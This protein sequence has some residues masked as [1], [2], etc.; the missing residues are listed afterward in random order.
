MR[1]I[2]LRLLNPPFV[3]VAKG[4]W[5]E[6]TRAY[7]FSITYK[8]PPSIGEQFSAGV[9]ALRLRVE[10]LCGMLFARVTEPAMRRTRYGELGAG[11]ASSR[12]RR[13]ASAPTLA[14]NIAP[15]RSAAWSGSCGGVPTHARSVRAGVSCRCAA[16]GR[17]EKG[18]RER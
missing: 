9:K 4:R 7:H 13:R 6:S 14:G 11:L 12:N 1:L 17:Q 8:Q 16:A 18:G 10:C 2:H 3:S 15:W 5:F